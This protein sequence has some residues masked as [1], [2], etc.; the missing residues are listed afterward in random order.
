MKKLPYGLSDFP[1]LI[2]E[3]YY[4]VDKPRYIELLENQPNYQFLLR[5]RR[6]GKSLFLAM[7]E[8]Y[9]SVDYTDRFEEL[10]GELYI[11][12]HA[13]KMPQRRIISIWCSDSIS[14]LSV[15]IL[16]KW[17]NRLKPTVVPQSLV[18]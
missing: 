4:Y 10:F 6:F 18:L 15:P 1:R 12:K 5:P 7:L 2:S 9:Y 14:P 16:M 13:T 8:T 17:N 3:D 11:G